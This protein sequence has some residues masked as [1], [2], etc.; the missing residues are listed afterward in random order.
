MAKAVKITGAQK[1]RWTFESKNDKT[2]AQK[3]LHNIFNGVLLQKRV[4]NED[5][6][7]IKKTSTTEI[8]LP[9]ICTKQK[10][11]RKYRLLKFSKSKLPK[12]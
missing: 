12:L 8:N 1:Q 2:N 9:T 6:Q 10:V 7:R 4:I 5:S 11:T 3:E